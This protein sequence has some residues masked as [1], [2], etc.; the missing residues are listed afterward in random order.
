MMVLQ[1]DDRTFVVTIVILAILATIFLAA[2]LLIKQLRK[3]TGS[4]DVMLIVGLIL[5]YGLMI[6]DMICE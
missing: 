1:G 4:D 5:A 3:A 2:R 6:N